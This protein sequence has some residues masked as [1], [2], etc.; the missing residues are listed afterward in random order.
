MM[1]AM[2]EKMVLI[3]WY[4]ACLLSRSMT[5]EDCI[6]EEMPIYKTFGILVKKDKVTVR[7]ASEI[8]KDGKQFREVSLIPAGSVISITRLGEKQ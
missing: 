8:T 2:I 5:R 6:S 3:E 1:E 7:I 4:D